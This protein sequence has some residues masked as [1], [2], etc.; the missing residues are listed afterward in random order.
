MNQPDQAIMTETTEIRAGASDT[1]TWKC[2]CTP[3]SWFPDKRVKLYDVNGDSGL[4]KVQTTDGRG[5]NV[6]KLGITLFKERGE[7]EY[8]H[9]SGLT[10]RK[11]G[12]IF[13][14][15]YQ[16]ITSSKE[17]SIRCP[18]D[19]EQKM[20]ETYFQFLKSLPDILAQHLKKTSELADWR[21]QPDVYLHT[22]MAAC[23]TG[24]LIHLVGVDTVLPG[25]GKV[26][27]RS[28]A[29]FPTFRKG[30]RSTA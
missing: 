7:K 6:S 15:L 17:F 21:G 10:S 27:F 3:K 24:L 1:L 12:L 16:M 4:T 25:V 20:F 22:L 2:C 23:N 11:S 8:L 30:A 14:V 9:A 28:D 26:D 29:R 18:L 13:P 19:K 5:K